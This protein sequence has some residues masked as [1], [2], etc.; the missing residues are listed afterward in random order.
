[1]NLSWN[2]SQCKCWK[3][4]RPR[5]HFLLQHTLCKILCLYLSGPQC[6]Q[7]YI[8]T[9]FEKTKTFSAGIKQHREQSATLVDSFLH[10]PLYLTYTELFSKTFLFF[11][12]K[13]NTLKW[14]DRH[15]REH[16]WQSCFCLVLCR[17]RSSVWRWMLP[18]QTRLFLQS[19]SLCTMRVCVQ[20]AESSSPNSS[21]PPGRCCRTSW[22]SLWCPTGTLRYADL[23]LLLMH[24]AA[25]KVERRFYVI[26]Q[27]L[28]ENFFCYC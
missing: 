1:M 13:D 21:S 11:S 8:L 16:M 12:V 17:F 2:N 10:W 20:P 9:Q 18:D 5:S 15:S 24:T 4:K 22:P 27:S 26:L 19:L 23:H 25:F 3:S 6:S 7:I 14:L 28:I